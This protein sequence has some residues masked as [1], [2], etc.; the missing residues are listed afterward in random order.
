MA[1]LVY[2]NKRTSAYLGKDC[3]GTSTKKHLAAQE[4]TRKNLSFRGTEDE[5]SNNEKASQGG[6]AC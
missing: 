1:V 6:V 4:T 3:P 2:A 5:D